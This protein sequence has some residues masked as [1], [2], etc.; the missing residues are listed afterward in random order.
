M[1]GLTKEGVLTRLPLAAEGWRDFLLS[2]GWADRCVVGEGC[3]LTTKEEA[4]RLR[5]LLTC[6]CETAAGSNA[7][8][9]RLP[10]RREYAKI[11]TD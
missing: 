4:G 9:A 5:R 10:Y 3:Q 8:Y 1:H 2:F 7:V 6:A 11:M